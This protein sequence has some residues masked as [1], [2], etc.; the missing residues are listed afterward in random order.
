MDVVVLD[1]IEKIAGAGN[2]LAGRR[3][4]FLAGPPL[5]D[6]P[7]KNS[8]ESVVPVEL[9]PL[10]PYIESLHIRQHMYH[11]PPIKKYVLMICTG[12]KT[13]RPTLILLYALLLFDIL[14]RAGLSAHML[15]ISAK[16]VPAILCLAPFGRELPF[17]NL[18]SIESAPNYG[19]I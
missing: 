1:Q 17:G 18:H 10:D 5:Q 7:I 12:G 6:L 13:T 4:L 9:H 11:S 8:L 14:R 2:Y 19:C 15:Q 3:P 16:A